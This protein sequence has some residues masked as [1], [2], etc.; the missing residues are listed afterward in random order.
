MGEE[1]H[2]RTPEKRHVYVGPTEKNIPVTI[3]QS[4]VEIL[5]SIGINGEIS[6]TEVYVSVNGNVEVVCLR[7]P[8]VK[9]GNVVD[10]E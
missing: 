8:C 4:G 7:P 10:S 3:T 6:G 5:E 9:S 2:R 1:R